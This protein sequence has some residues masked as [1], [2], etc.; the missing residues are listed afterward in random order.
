MLRRAP[1]FGTVMEGPAVLLPEPHSDE[2]GLFAR[3]F[4]PDEFRAIAV[5]FK[6]VQTSLSRNPVKYTLRGLHYQSGEWSE[7]KIVRAVRGAV[8]DVAVDLRPG[9][10]TYR[11]WCAT[12]LSAENL[13]AFYIPWGFLHG[14]LTLEPDTDVLYEIDRMF[15][16]GHGAGFRWNDPAFSIEWPAMPMLIGARDAGYADFIGNP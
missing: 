13:A 10:K 7:G 2:R 5:E 9:S 14:F 11:K 1:E 6:S 12:I 4:C 8:Y 3:L 15:E 16:P